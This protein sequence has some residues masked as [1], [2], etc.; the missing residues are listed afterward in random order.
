MS[1]LI[2]EP[3]LEAPDEFYEALIE[4]HR[5][6][7]TAQSHELNAKLVLLLANH[8][9]ELAVLRQALEAAR[10]SVLLNHPEAAAGQP[11]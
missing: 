3:H 2:T 9:G 4:T 11:A 6:L 10:A 1:T 7:S 8:I 5:D